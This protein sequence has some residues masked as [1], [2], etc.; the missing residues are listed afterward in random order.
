MGVRSV[1]VL[2]GVEETEV[3]EKGMFN[4]IK[5]YDNLLIF[6]QLIIL[7]VFITAR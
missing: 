1:K 6:E 4:C 5:G 7:G 2:R 3:V